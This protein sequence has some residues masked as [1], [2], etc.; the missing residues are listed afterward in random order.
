M[1]KL[2]AAQGMIINNREYLEERDKHFNIWMRLMRKGAHPSV[3]SI[4]HSFC[5]MIFGL[6]EILHHLRC[7][8]LCA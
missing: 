4:K 2:I 3:G 8:K 5:Q 6:D 1:L 7:I